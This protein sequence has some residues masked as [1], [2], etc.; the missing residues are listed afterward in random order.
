MQCGARYVLSSGYQTEWLA[1]AGCAAL[2]LHQAA[3]AGHG[4]AARESEGRAGGSAEVKHPALMWSETTLRY[5]SSPEVWHACTQ[6]LAGRLKTSS[7]WQPS[8]EGTAGFAARVLRA[9]SFLTHSEAPAVA[10]VCKPALQLLLASHRERAN[11]N[12]RPP[13]SAAQLRTTLDDFHQKLSVVEAAISGVGAAISDD[14]QAGWRL[15]PDR[16]HLQPGMI[17]GQSA[18]ASI[19][20]AMCWTLLAKAQ[21]L[22]E[23]GAASALGEDTAALL[24]PDAEVAPDVCFVLPRAGCV[25]AGRDPSTRPLKQLYLQ[26]ST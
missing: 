19:R 17:P 21:C 22:G 18:R 1:A 5:R 16:V 9:A 23:V 25:P 4:I 7:V 14:D 20:E 12:W 11:H 6:L 2:V 8:A 10:A 26:P 24:G 13:E 3:L 15:A